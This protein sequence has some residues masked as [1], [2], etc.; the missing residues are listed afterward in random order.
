[1]GKSRRKLFL[2]ATVSGVTL[3]L[4]LPGLAD[5]ISLIWETARTPLEHV[6]PS[7]LASGLSLISLAVFFLVTYLG[8]TQ[9]GYKEGN[10]R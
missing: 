5:C 4:G 9:L 7:N 2:T 1:M 10:P 3:I 6:V 8:V